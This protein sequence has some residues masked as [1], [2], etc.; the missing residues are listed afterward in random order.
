MIK[1][2]EIS[3]VDTES[4]ENAKIGPKNGDPLCPHTQIACLFRETEQKDGQ[5]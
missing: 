2:K 3:C 5:N 1:N 4:N